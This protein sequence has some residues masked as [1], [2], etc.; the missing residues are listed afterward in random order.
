MS[1]DIYDYNTLLNHQKNFD[2]FNQ[3]E[4][5]KKYNPYQEFLTDEEIKIKREL[6]KKSNIAAK[7]EYKEAKFYN[8][9]IKE[10]M[11][12]FLM[13]W[14]NI[15]IELININYK[16]K[17]TSWWNII[18]KIGMDIIYILTKKD[19]LIYVGMM[20]IIISIFIYYII[21]SK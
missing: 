13:N 15:I 12:N 19:R 1:N 9:S 5:D 16:N 20:M 3:N 6:E 17:S 10:I 14:N 18:Y 8:L 21:I 11:N 2:F 4:N 7:I